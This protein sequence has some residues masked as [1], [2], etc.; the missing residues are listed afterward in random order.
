MKGTPHA[1]FTLYLNDTTMGLHRAKGH[2]QAQ[3]G[4]LVLFLGGEKRFKNMLLVCI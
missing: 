2:G 3:A 1:G 4:S